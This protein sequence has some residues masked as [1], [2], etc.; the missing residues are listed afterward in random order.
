MELLKR[1]PLALLGRICMAA[2]FV[3]TLWLSGCDD[4]GWDRDHDRGD[5]FEHHDHD[6]HDHHEDHDHR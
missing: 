1:G 4:H 5:H 3:G 2:F 6:D